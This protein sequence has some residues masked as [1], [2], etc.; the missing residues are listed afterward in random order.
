MLKIDRRRFLK[1]S[2]AATG[3]LLAP[4]LLSDFFILNNPPIAFA[5]TRATQLS[6]IEAKYYRKLEHK[7]IECQLCPR[8]CK[9]GD[10]ER[11]Y[12]GVRENQNG[13]YYTL[14]H[15]L[16]CS[17]GIDHIEK[18]PFFHFLPG[19]FAFS[20][21]TAGCN[22]NCKFCQNWQ[23]SQV[24]PEQVDNL[25]IS[26][27][28][29]ANYALEN[30]CPSIAYTYSEPVVF[31]EYMLD[32]AKE[33]RKRGIKSVV[34]SGGY[35]NHEPLMELCGAVDAIKIDFKGFTEKYYKEVCR[36]E[37]KPVM[38]CL[39]DLSKNGI[40]YEIVY[41]VVPTLNDDL[42]VIR[43]MCDWLV[44]DLGSNVP[45]HFSRFSPLYLLKNLPP[46]PVST[47]EKARKIALDSG[48]SYV[49]IGN[50]IG[51]EGENTYC[52]KCKKKVIGRVGYTITGFKIKKGKCQ[53]CGQK[54]PGVWE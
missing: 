2:L 49:Y 52:S 37:L 22:L 18:K 7:E 53:F 31:Y 17:R 26:P 3:G 12:C 43:K 16:V 36:G 51:H 28:M 45:L 20:I 48:M 40:W 39:I 13:T 46:T 6:H 32:C 44:K 27:E 5:Q 19:S 42:Q 24:R 54:I 50:V 11:G 10:K 30:D 15:S 14:V 41:L 33:G 34:V 38:D 23:I 35:I 21:A 9:V 4:K 29:V 1:T 25:L 47:L 8:K